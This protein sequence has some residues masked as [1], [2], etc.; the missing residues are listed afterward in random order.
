MSQTELT[1]RYATFAVL[2]TLV[3][4]GAQWVSFHLYRG[5]GELPLG[6]AAG[7]LAG[8]VTKYVLDKFWIFG[9][10]SFKTLE[11][12]YRFTLYTFTGLFTTSIFW[13]MEALFA[14]LSVHE[15]MRY[16]GALTGLSLGYVMKFYLDRRLVFQVRS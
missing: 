4:L 16:L 14:A 7:T 12:M 15:E 1:L 2:A 9:D 5:P 8:L 11:N 6:I 3:N 10:R 13:G